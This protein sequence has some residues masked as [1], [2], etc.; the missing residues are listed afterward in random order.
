MTAPLLL[1]RACSW[2]P[3]LVVE[4]DPSKTTARTLLSCAYIRLIAMFKIPYFAINRLCE[5]AGYLNTHDLAYRGLLVAATV[6]RLR[7]ARVEGAAWRQVAQQGCE[8]GYAGERAARLE[9][10]QCRDQRLRVRMLRAS[11]DVGDRRHL[12][13][14]P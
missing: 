6:H 1:Q 12:D 2:S 11:D 9:R 13:Q 7:A 4:V 5:M 14:P 10:G 3:S 8:T